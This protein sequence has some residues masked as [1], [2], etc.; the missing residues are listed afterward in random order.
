MVYRASKRKRYELR[1]KIWVFKCKYFRQWGHLTERHRRGR[2]SIKW[3]RICFEEH[4]DDDESQK[5]SGKVR[6]S[7]K[8]R[9]VIEIFMSPFSAES[10][11]NAGNDW[12]SSTEFKEN[13]IPRTQ[14]AYSLVGRRGKWSK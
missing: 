13:K 6:R 10:S 9:T 3:R 7:N 8:E 5:A 12:P 14:V 2:G 11:I 4:R 1:Q